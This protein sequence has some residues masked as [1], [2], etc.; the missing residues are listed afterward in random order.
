[1]AYSGGYMELTWDA[2]RGRYRELWK[3][4]RPW[5]MIEWLI[6]GAQLIG[7]TRRLYRVEIPPD[8]PRPLRFLYENHVTA[9]FA[10]GTSSTKPMAEELRALGEEFL[11]QEGQWRK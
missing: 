6:P 7:H 2:E 11:D 3:R 4:M 9:L 10:L 8:Q 5:T 1:M